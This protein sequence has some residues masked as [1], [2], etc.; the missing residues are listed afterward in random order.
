[1]EIPE[2]PVLFGHDP[3]EGIVAANP[4]GDDQIR[5]ILR[6][7]G[8]RRAE[9]HPLR[10]VIWTR[11]GTDWPGAKARRLEG[12][13]HFNTLLECDD[14]KAYQS[15]RQGLREEGADHFTVN[16]PAQQFLMRSG[17]TF[18]K[19]MHFEDLKRLQLDIETH[20]DPAFEFSNPDRES[21]HILAIALSDSSGWEAFLTV[22]PDDW[23]TS[24]KTALIELTRLI[25]ERDPDVIEGHN[26]F[27][28]DLDYIHR[29]ARRHRAKLAWGRDGSRLTTR[30]SRLQVA[31]RTIAYP[32]FDV[33][34][35][36]I[37][38]TFLLAQFHDVGSRSLEGFGLKE[39]ARHFGVAG[40]DGAPDRVTL[41]GRA[42]QQ[43]ATD[44]PDAFREYAL[45]D[46]RETRALADLLS[47]SY[48]SQAQIFPYDYQ[49]VVLRGNATK[50]DSL[51]L[52]EY[53][54]Q[55]HALPP[56]PD[57]R[58]FEGGY[59]DVFL[60]GVARP[61][62]HCDVTSLY[63]SVM[64]RFNL[65]PKTDDL[66]IFRGLLADLRRFR[67]EAK[68][69]LRA[70]RDHSSREYHATNALQST[71][72]ILINSFYGYLGFSQAHFADFD[73][74]SEVTRTGRDLLRGMVDWLDS[75]GSRVVE[76][77]TDGVYF[78]PPEGATSAAVDEGLRRDVLP[79]GIDIEF[80]T[81][82]TAMFSYKAK[83]YA[84]LRETGEL[85]IK[86]G[87]LRSRGL[88]RFQREFLER[89]LRLLIDNDSDAV[90]RLHSEFSDAI[91][92]RLWPID[93]LA[94][95]ET[96][97]DSLARYTEKIK[98]NARNRAAAYELAR[99]SPRDYQPGDQITYYV[100]GTKKR[101]P[102]H[103]NCKLAAE[104]NPDDRDENT[105]YYKAKLDDLVKKFAPFID[106]PGLRTAADSGRT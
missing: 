88:E 49:N 39:V 105:A 7:G 78:I 71:F 102:V 4:E 1:M 11:D 6:D 2:N 18:F 93:R 36:H 55:H 8:N 45:Q 25:G 65:L 42:I 66:G 61:V 70:I 83:N 51:F 44:D 29:R 90:R 33:N 17:M 57:V 80:D 69:R 20:C 9:S 52:R 16:D 35:R 47:R 67:I 23:R 15:L 81:S 72:K 26:I 53:L 31:E 79:D 63:P 5:L 96:L 24:E 103:E 50:I 82:F 19:G 3:T 41:E 34:G 54:R 104:W 68:S 87:A 73:A 74:A 30:A 97:Q 101:V 98:G 99:A 27:R 22:D 77:D 14:W 86:G 12:D 48:F 85:V 75:H 84:L 76:I 28:F 21:D 91:E 10:P 43:A 32:R 13:R 92:N 94:K 40:G 100:T 37:V 46:V 60:T 56:T 58:R 38:D 89:M 95:T 62:W 106:N 64:L 59:T